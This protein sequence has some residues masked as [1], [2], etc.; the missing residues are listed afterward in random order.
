MQANIFFGNVIVDQQI[1]SY[2]ENT[3]DVIDLSDHE[4]LLS[5]FEFIITFNIN[6]CYDDFIN[7]IKTFKKSKDSIIMS[8]PTSSYSIQFMKNNINNNLQNN[9]QSK[10][11]DIQDI[12]VPD[13]INKKTII[14]KYS[15]IE[16]K[17]NHKPILKFETE[18]KIRY[19]ND[20]IVSTKGDRYV[21]I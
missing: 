15:L 12:I 14:E 4:E 7:T 13:I 5:L 11:P 3:L 10:K 20:R 9:M 21:N 2:V 1:L 16:D 17:L 6:L 8:E 18:K 19:L